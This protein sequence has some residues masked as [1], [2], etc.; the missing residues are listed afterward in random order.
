MI[1]AFDTETHIIGPGAV[2][3]K[4]VCATFATRDDGDPTGVRSSLI[5]NHS[6][7]DLEGRL[8]W[9]LTEDLTIV[10]HSGGFDWAVV[11]ANFP[12]LIPLVFDALLSG[13]C[14]CTVQRERLLNLSTTGKLEKLYLP[15]GSTTPILYSLAD[16]EMKYLGVDRSLEK[17]SDDSWRLAFAALDGWR[18][19]EY[20]EDAAKY[21]TE[22]AIG[23][24]LVYEAQERRKVDFPYASTA[25]EGFQAAAH[26]AL[27]LST[28]H[29]IEVNPEETAKMRAELLARLAAVEGDLVAAGFLRP[30]LPAAPYKSQ[31]KRVTQWFKERH[32]L[33]VLTPAD[34]LD[35]SQ[36]G[37]RE[38]LEVIGVK[39]TAPEESS[40][41]QANVQAHVK[42]LYQ[43]LGEIPAMTAGGEKREPQIVLD[44]E[45]QEYLAMKDELMEKYQA[46]QSVGKLV[47][48]CDI[49]ESG[50]VIYPNYN[51]IV[52]TGRTS[53]YGSSKKRPA[54]Y[55]STNIQQVPNEMEGLDP[56]RCYR[57]REGTV[58]WDVDVTNLELADVGQTTFD[59]FGESVHLAK[60]NAGVDLH[61]YLATSLQLQLATDGVGREFQEECRREGILSDDEASYQAFMLCKRST[62]EP[63]RKWFKDSRNF[64]KPVGLGFPGG[65]GP[66]TMVEFAWG[67]YRVRMTEEQ[68][69]DSREVWR[70]RYPEMP[71]YFDWISSQLD[72]Y[73]VGKGGEQLYWYQ[74]PY[75]MIRRGASYCAAANGKAMQ[76]PGAEG[77]KTW[78]IR[79]QRECYDPTQ[80]SVLF[81]SRSVAFIHD[82]IVG[83]TTR[84][85]Q[86]WHDQCMRVKQLLV[87]TMPL[88]LPDVKIRSDEAHLTRV[89]TKA[90]E[91]VFGPD[92]RLI[93]W[94]P[95]A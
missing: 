86:L 52:E 65:L 83:E 89:W 66:K 3:P 91:P 22:D 10:T 88:V 12:A 9:L 59:L 93:P 43:R 48:Q 15:D 60:Y 87:E 38:A 53:S 51:V 80:E 44:G 94:E 70:G 62:E 49:L 14:T 95:K 84:D 57:P 18:S 73:N 74:T 20:P 75:G 5:S 27:Q 90:S 46:R 24:L 61:G 58:F 81:G 26:F 68:A 25:T 55:P 28:A 31:M 69:S 78:F 11:A 92:M 13:R 34:I 63:V 23:T 1:V 2:A 7:E 45:V 36:G 32:D 79:V 42:A 8:R 56:R 21:A 85:E 39:F 76:S 72:E 16:L 19:S 4:I 30:A 67:T 64:A 47:D 77:A 71:R 40:V 50:P 82:Q 37:V 35:W 17:T 33:P 6:D 29:G 54:L 41:I